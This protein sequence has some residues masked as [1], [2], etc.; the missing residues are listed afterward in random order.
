MRTGE[1]NLNPYP[2]MTCLRLIHRVSYTSPHVNSQGIKKK[3]KFDWSLAGW[4]VPSWTVMR[5]LDLFLFSLFYQCS[6]RGI[7]SDPRV[8]EATVKR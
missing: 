3:K 8:F 7:F 2:E 5:E 1:E 4:I 6:E